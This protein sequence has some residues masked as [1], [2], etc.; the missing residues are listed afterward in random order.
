MT[1]II[2]W[3]AEFVGEVIVATVMQFFS[4]VLV[5]WVAEAA[6][7]VVAEWLTALV[8]DMTRLFTALLTGVRR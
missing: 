5:G 2:I 4:E 1:S 7:S 6:Q 8:A 3:I